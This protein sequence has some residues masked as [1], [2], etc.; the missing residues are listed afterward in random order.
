MNKNSKSVKHAKAILKY[1][2]KPFCICLLKY[3]DELEKKAYMCEYYEEHANIFYNELTAVRK[4]NAIN[5][6]TIEKIEEIIRE[7]KKRL[8]T[9][10]SSY[11]VNDIE[12]RK[13]CQYARAKLTF[14]L[15]DI[16]KLMK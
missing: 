7:Y 12:N 13:A 10:E 2:N 14:L 11:D 15:E 8:D 4:N 3:I 5:E 6:F 16:Y 9:E 1:W